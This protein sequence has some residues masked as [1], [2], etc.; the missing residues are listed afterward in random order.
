MVQGA[1]DY[2]LCSDADRCHGDGLDGLPH[3]WSH[4]AGIVETGDGPLTSTFGMFGANVAPFFP[5]F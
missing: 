2:V 5:P 3:G 4:A 1:L